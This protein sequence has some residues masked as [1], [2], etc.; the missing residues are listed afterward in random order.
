[1]PITSFWAAAAKRVPL[2]FGQAYAQCLV[3]VRFNVSAHWRNSS[4]E[5]YR[6]QR[7]AA[8]VVSLLPVGGAPPRIGRAEEQGAS[9]EKDRSQLHGG[10]MRVGGLRL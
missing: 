4:A 2:L 8:Q 7:L 5:T 9:R 10:R 6:V 3:V 1:M